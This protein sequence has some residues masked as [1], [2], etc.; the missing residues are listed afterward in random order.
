MQTPSPMHLN[1]SHVGF[2]SFFHLSLRKRKETWIHIYM[3][4]LSGQT[5]P[6][7]MACFKGFHRNQI[8]KDP[9]AFSDLR[10]DLF[11]TVTITENG[12]KKAVPG[13]TQDQLHILQ[14]RHRWQQGGGQSV[15]HCPPRRP[16]C[17][18]CKGKIFINNR[19]YSCINNGGLI[20]NGQFPQ[21]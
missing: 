1:T 2:E 18:P 14:T 10:G 17:Q 7:A 21:K 6:H 3:F 11:T 13:L 4:T 16:C 9:T 12:K 15:L 5:M 19:P 8:T 20:D